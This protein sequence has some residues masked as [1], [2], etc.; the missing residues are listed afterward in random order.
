MERPLGKKSKTVAGFN[1]R[2]IM[3]FSNQILFII[4][5][6]HS[7]VWVKTEDVVSAISLYFLF[8]HAVFL[9]R[10]IYFFQ[11]LT[12]YNGYEL[13]KI[14]LGDLA[15]SPRTFPTV[16]SIQLIFWVTNQ[17]LLWHHTSNF[18]QAKKMIDWIWVFISQVK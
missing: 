18:F 8:S 9:W 5:V 10:V 16:K 4:S 1:G 13:T 14:F 7:L 11:I 2:A 3:M 17:L 12:T 15:Y 6:F